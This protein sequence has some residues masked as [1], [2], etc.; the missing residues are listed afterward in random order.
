MDFYE[1]QRSRS[2][3]RSAL[4]PARRSHG[5]GFESIQRRAVPMITLGGFDAPLTRA[6][7]E[8]QIR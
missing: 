3:F 4:V 6:H 1:S 7:I 2:H 8:G 5:L